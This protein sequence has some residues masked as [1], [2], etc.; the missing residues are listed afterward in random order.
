MVRENN[1]RQILGD[2]QRIML[3]V[4]GHSSHTDPD[5]GDRT[6]LSNTCFQLHTDTADH[7]DK[8]L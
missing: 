6:S 3:Q 7:P 8:I 5:D 4:N 1:G 2:K